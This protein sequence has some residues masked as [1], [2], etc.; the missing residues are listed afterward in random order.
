MRDHKN[1]H[2]RAHV[3]TKGIRFECQRCCKCCYG[4][5]ILSYS[6][7]ENIRKNDGKFMWAIT[8]TTSSRYPHQGEFYTIVHTAHPNEKGK[9]G[10]CAYLEDNA[11]QI[12]SERP[13]TCRTYPFS[14]EL[15]KKM[16][17][18]RRLHRHSPVFIDPNNSKK[19]VVVFDP[20]C[21]GIGKGSEVNLEKIASAELDNISKVSET[22]KTELKNKIKDLICPEEVKKEI[23]EYEAGMKLLTENRKVK[24]DMAEKDLF[25]H[26]VYNP[27]DIN[28][29]DAKKLVTHAIH[30]WRTGFPE[31]STIMIY[32][33]FP[34][35]G[36]NGL[37]KIYVG[38]MPLKSDSITPNDLEAV[39]SAL[40]V[41]EEL[42]KKSKTKVGFAN[43]R[44]ENG[45][46]ITPK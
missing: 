24:T 19:Y 4:E 42:R 46:W 35:G 5:I 33:T 2:E 32:Y 3:A 21:P 41:S 29:E 34:V 8:P 31:T 7:I 17:E 11:C 30:I 13:M 9:K 22:Y 16:K 26:V 44:F 43:V 6:D 36:K 28:K 39:F 1:W 40:M 15:K 38:V 14:V 45:R 20:E 37:I 10:L 23:E 12:Y 25:I 27:K 18:K